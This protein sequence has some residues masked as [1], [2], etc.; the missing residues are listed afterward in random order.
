MK[1]VLSLAVL[2]LPLCSMASTEMRNFVYDGSQSSVE[3]SMRTEK[4][5]TEYKT[6]QVP[7]TC[8][9]REV[10]G[11]RTT[12]MGGYY[13]SPIGLPGNFP[14]GYNDPRNRF[15]S[16]GPHYGGSS[17][18]QEPIYRSVPYSC[19]KTETISYQVKD[20]DV[21][22]K[23]TLNV[24]KNTTFAGTENFTVVL[25]GDSVNVT[26][27]GSKNYLA[28]LKRP[29]INANMNGSVKLMDAVLTVELI[30]AA[31]VLHSLKMNDISI[32]NGVLSLGLGLIT[33]SEHIK[34]SLN[35]TKK[36]IGSDLV[37]FD[38]E[39][40]ASE[41]VLKASRAGTDA[42]VNVNKLG[43]SLDGGKYALTARASFRADGTL[44]NRVQ[45]GDEALSTAR[46]LIY[47]IR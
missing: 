26:V 12:C 24:A 3:F 36:K 4:T 25:N 18:I 39:L 7:S 20:Y 32:E 16:R 44:I 10:M 27:A 29:V 14:G 13:P 23:V 6:E 34:I 30:E 8:Y 41:V 47:K 28:V 43:L 38:R 17:C 1:L 21:D 45:F 11:Y 37:M 2:S 33:A 15:P 9:N 31:P 46:T 22:A 35:V 40:K 5:H 42:E 19:L